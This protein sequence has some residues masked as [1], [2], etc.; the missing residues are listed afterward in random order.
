MKTTLVTAANG[1]TGQHVIAA[2]RSRPETGSIRGFALRPVQSAD[3]TAQ[4]DMCELRSIEHAVKGVDTVIHYG[5]AM[6]PRETAMGTDMIDAAQAAGVRRF[7][8]ISVIHPEIENLLNHKAKL[9]VEAHLVNSRLDWTVVRPQHYM[10]NIPVAKVV[11]DGRLV[12]PYPVTT[13]LGH[14]DMQDLAEAV[15]T[16][17][18]EGGHSYATYDI[19][20]EE[21]LSVENICQAIARIS[22]TF[23][24]AKAIDPYALIDIIKAHWRGPL[25]DYSIEGFHRL[26]GYYARHGIRGNARVLT[27]LLNRP[28]GTFDG[29]VRRCLAAES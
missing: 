3:E 27:W 8:Y 13:R 29:Y 21:D 14:V 9:A 24:Q 4:G 5:P 20:A 17:A 7:V 28:P 10:Q 22:G 15:A 6:H 1:R 19:S 25:S 12:M 11:A 26:F 16:V 18:S 2:L 23:I